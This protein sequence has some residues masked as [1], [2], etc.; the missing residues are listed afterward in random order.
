MQ[1]YSPNMKVCATCERWAGPRRVNSTRSA[2]T[3]TSTAVKGECLGGGHNHALTPPTASCSKHV[4]WPI[5][6]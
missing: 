1:N 2:V 6:R 5:L 4:K 3:T